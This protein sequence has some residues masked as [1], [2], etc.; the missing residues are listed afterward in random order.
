METTISSDEGMLWIQFMTNP[1][2]YASD[3]QRENILP[4]WEE[5]SVFDYMLIVDMA[6]CILFLSLHY[7]LMLFR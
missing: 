5:N 4:N 3:T 2:L 1:V 7:L 6:D